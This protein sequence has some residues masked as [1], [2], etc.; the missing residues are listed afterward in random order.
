[1]SQRMHIPVL[2]YHGVNIHRNDYAGNDHIALYEDL[3]LI[4]RQGLRVIPLKQIAEWVSGRVGDAEVSTGVGISFDDGS[5]FDWHDLEHPACGLQRSMAGI[6]RD[7]A[8]ETGDAASATSFLIASPEARETLDQ[9]CLIGKGWWGD[10]WWERAARE[11]LVALGNHSWD[12]LHPTLES[13]AHSRNVKGDFLAVDNLEDARRQIAA[14]SREIGAR[15]GERP[16]LF[17]YPCGQAPDYLVEE[18][19]PGYQNEHGLVA[20]FTTEPRPV[21]RDDNVWKLPRMVCG[22]AWSSPEELAAILAVCRT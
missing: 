20:A 11:G 12:H 1:M 2:T 3:R 22:E 18:Y 6:L 10:E 7:F 13:V 5:W 19:F 15:S 14:A 8:R 9:T 21:C 17:A 4:R 16:C